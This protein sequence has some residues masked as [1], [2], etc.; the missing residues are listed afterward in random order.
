MA[1]CCFGYTSA[2][3]ITGGFAIECCKKHL[4]STN[5]K[6]MLMGTQI[7]K[8]LVSFVLSSATVRKVN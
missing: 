8:V 3:A 7:H 6:I 5:T 2:N 1:T 4:F